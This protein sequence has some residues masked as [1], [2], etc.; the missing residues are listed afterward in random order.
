MFLNDVKDY[1]KIDRRIQY[2]FSASM[3]FQI[4]PTHLD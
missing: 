3:K 2:Y 4:P 1:R